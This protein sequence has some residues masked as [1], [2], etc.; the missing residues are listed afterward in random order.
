MPDDQELVRE[1]LSGSEA[2]MEV[3]TRK[4]YRPIFA[5]VY[6]KV[7][8]K[9]IAYDLT[10]E[11]FIKMMKKIHT[12]SNKKKFSSWLFMIALN[13]C[14]DYWKSNEF[15]RLSMQTEL[16]DIQQNEQQQVSYIFENKE[17]REQIKQ[18]MESLPEY[19]KEAL[20]LKYFHQMK[21]KEIAELTNSNAST[22]KSRL[23]QGIGK[24]A[25]LLRKEE[26]VNEQISKRGY[27]N[28]RNP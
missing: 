28:R 19:Q 2:A 22:V 18:A 24:L 27:G 26:G 14:R 11:I 5:F 16:Q 8:E 25:V 20:I 13:H 12:Y 17:T 9:E 23:K 3:L 1:I 10:Q 4:Y 21:I 6:R 15:K 7:G